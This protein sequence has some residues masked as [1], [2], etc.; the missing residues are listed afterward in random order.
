MINQQENTHY[1]ST[2]DI[3]SNV[4]IA[5]HPVHPMLI[6]L[7]LAALLGAL[8]SDFLYTRTEDRFF[9]RSSNLFLGTG[10]ITGLLA[11]AVGAVDYTTIR[12]VRENPVAT[13][14][15]VGNVAA[16]G[17]AAINLL[18]RRDNPRRVNGAQFFLSAI[19]GGLL[20]ITGWLGGELSYRYKIGVKSE[21]MPN[22]PSFPSSYERYETDIAG[23]NNPAIG[24]SAA[25]RTY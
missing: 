17:L 4:N 16:L 22:T 12:P 2:P 6:S 9:A 13:A 18:S 5:G 7:P 20:G 3:P 8:A 25:S 19:T 11:G 10:I 21:P 15:M 1:S 14:H 24:G 23:A